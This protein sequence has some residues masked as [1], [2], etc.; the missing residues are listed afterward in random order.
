MANNAAMIQHNCMDNSH[1]LGGIAVE[2]EQ[3]FKKSECS[4]CIVGRHRMMAAVDDSCTEGSL[5]DEMTA[6]DV[7]A[8]DAGVPVVANC[9]D[10]GSHWDKVTIDGATVRDVGAA[11]I[12]AT[13]EVIAV[14]FV[15]S[16]NEHNS[17]TAT[18]MLV[19]VWTVNRK[20]NCNVS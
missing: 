14:M 10:R 4:L 19:K 17:P 1:C 16:I 8:T 6:D 7:D 13:V 20:Q 11:D 3:S 15:M 12:S 9:C 5:R 2:K 18:I